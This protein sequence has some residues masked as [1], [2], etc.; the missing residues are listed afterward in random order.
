[1]AGEQG[2]LGLSEDFPKLVKILANTE[3]DFDYWNDLVQKLY[4][5]VDQGTFRSYF[6]NMVWVHLDKQFPSCPEL[7]NDWGFMRD[8]YVT[9]LEGTKYRVKREEMLHSPLKEF[10]EDAS[11]P[12]LVKIK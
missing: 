9:N 2:L 5:K 10:I 11:I 7:E 4:E 8:K 3:K 1:M 6:K 12:I